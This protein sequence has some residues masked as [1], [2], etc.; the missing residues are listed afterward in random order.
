MEPK[1]ISVW[2]RRF[3]NQRRDGRRLEARRPPRRRRY[4]ELAYDARAFGY[5]RLSAFGRRRPYRDE[6]NRH[7]RGWPFHDHYH[8]CSFQHPFPERVSGS[9]Q[10]IH[11][12]EGAASAENELIWSPK[13]P[14]SRSIPP[15]HQSYYLPSRLRAT[16]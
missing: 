11:S 14:P 9:A 15:P 6:R 16:T 3:A 2:P 7:H 5:P 10:E 13:P 4:R 8:A 12:Q 1:E